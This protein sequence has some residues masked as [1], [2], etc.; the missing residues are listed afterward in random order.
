MNGTIA[1]T[2]PT[3]TEIVQ[4]MRIER[5]IPAWAMRVRKLSFFL[6]CFS[7]KVGSLLLV[8]LLTFKLLSEHRRPAFFGRDPFASY[9]WRIVA[10]VLIVTAL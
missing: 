8:T 7:R 9:Q 10:D 3:I 2:I 6:R 4:N 1:M 5:S